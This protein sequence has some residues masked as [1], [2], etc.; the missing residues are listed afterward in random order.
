MPVYQQIA[1]R[2]TALRE[3]ELSDRR[4]GQEL[5]VEPKTAVKAIAWFA[6]S[7]IVKKSPSA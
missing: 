1:A 6:E 5:G 4:I 2:A 3:Q 7:P